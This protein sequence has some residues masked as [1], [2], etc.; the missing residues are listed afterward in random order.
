MRLSHS[1]AWLLMSFAS[2]IICSE[3]EAQLQRGQVDKNV[4]DVAGGDIAQGSNLASVS[5]PLQSRC[6]S[7]WGTRN[8]S[9]DFTNINEDSN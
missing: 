3:V 2:E 9:L 5:L 7:W 6:V 1:I 4:G 8:Y